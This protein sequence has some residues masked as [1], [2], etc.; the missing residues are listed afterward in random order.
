MSA[1]TLLI[2][3]KL[4]TSREVR[5]VPDRTHASQQLSVLFDHLV[6]PQQQ[7]PARQ[8]GRFVGF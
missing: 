6:D 8:A 7:M 2:A 4:R 1:F 3:A 5:S